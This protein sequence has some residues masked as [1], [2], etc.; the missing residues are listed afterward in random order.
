MNYWERRKIYVIAAVA[1]LAISYN[2][3]TKAPEKI[4]IERI[5]PVTKTENTKSEREILFYVTG[6]VALPGVYTIDK[7][8]RV[9]K[10]IALAGG[11]REDADQDK[12]NLVQKVKDGMHIK[13]PYLKVEKKK[14]GERQKEKTKKNIPQTKNTLEKININNADEKTLQKIKGV[15]PKTA[16]KIIQYRKEKRFTSLEEIKFV[17]GITEEKFKRMKEQLTV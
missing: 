17:P 16:Q 3:F 6:A 8:G 14:S 11:F 12:I 4:Q 1:V 15:G 10:A 9:S 7:G 5:S 2:L 13:V